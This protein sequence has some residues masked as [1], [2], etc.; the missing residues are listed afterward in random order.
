MDLGLTRVF[1]CLH[2]DGTSAKEE[3]S[4]IKPQQPDA[5]SAAA[6]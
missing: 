2:D 5:A 3:M 4:Y 1:V 6:H